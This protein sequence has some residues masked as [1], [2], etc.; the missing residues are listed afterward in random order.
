MSTPK[1]Y[2]LTRVGAGPGQAVFV[3]DKLLGRE[4]EVVDAADYDALHNQ[5]RLM[6]DALRTHAAGLRQTML[7]LDQTAGVL[8]GWAQKFDP[9]DIPR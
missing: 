3:C 2:T 5:Y 6:A 9:Q 7:F 8:L 1:R 4:V